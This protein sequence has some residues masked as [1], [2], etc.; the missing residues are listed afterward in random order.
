MTCPF[1]NI[2]CM[3]NKFMFHF[4][5]EQRIFSLKKKIFKVNKYKSKIN[6]NN[7]NNNIFPKHFKIFQKIDLAGMIK[8]RVKNIEILKI[9]KNLEET[10]DLI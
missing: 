7:N 2:S 6:S 5:I 4:H 1:P 10:N 8:P 9:K 3:I